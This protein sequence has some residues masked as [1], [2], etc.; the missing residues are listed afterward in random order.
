[1]EKS[2]SLYLF[3]NN[4]KNQNYVM[5]NTSS[6]GMQINNLRMQHMV[7]QDLVVLVNQKL[8]HIMEKFI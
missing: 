8:V 1:M 2:L 3:S 5:H 4:K 7:N 6:G